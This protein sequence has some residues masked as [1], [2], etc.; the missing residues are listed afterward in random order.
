VRSARPR[1]GAR[2]VGLLAV[3]VLLL[4]GALSG[5]ATTQE[6]AAKKQ[7]ESKRILEA[8]EK[9]QSRQSKTNDHGSRKR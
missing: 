9:R 1:H 7:A 2:L 3:C 6:T 5:C 8:R 4:P